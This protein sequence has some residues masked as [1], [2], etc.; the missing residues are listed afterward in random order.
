[1]K[2]SLLITSSKVLKIF[3]KRMNSNNLIVK[4]KK[5]NFN[6]HYATKRRRVE[7]KTTGMSL[8][9]IV[10]SFPIQNKVKLINYINYISTS[11]QSSLTFIPLDYIYFVLQWTL[12][13]YCILL[14]NFSFTWGPCPPSSGSVIIVA[15]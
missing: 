13:F 5:V 8:V 15:C 2:R 11:N 12:Q 7:A 6:S 4:R 1:M 14:P 9:N 10:Q 3:Y